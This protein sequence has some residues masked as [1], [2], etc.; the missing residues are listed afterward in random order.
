MTET[1]A[2]NIPLSIAGQMHMAAEHVTGLQQVNKAKG[3]R[4]M[5][6]AT[7][8]KEIHVL[9]ILISRVYLNAKKKYTFIFYV[10]R[11]ME[12]QYYSMK[13]KNMIDLY[14]SSS[15][16]VRKVWY[17]ISGHPEFFFGSG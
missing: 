14:F 13:L 1:I 8:K 12:A 6:I 5:I 7:P 16:A 4:H 11:Q 9:P 17:V 15:Y 10:K 2:F 3:Q